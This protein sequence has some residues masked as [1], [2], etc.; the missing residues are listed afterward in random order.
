MST[1]DTRELIISVDLKI[2]K[3]SGLFYRTRLAK[4]NSPGQQGT[5]A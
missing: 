5:K 4:G 2:S 1:E 3:H